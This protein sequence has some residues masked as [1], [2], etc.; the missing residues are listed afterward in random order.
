MDCFYL[1]YIEKIVRKTKRIIF[2]KLDR[3]II[4]QNDLEDRSDLLCMA[5]DYSPRIE[6]KEVLESRTKYVFQN[7]NKKQQLRANKLDS[8]NDKLFTLN[9]K[10][11][12]DF[13]QHIG[14]NNLI[15]VCKCTS[16]IENEPD[17]NQE[18]KQKKKSYSK[19]FEYLSEKNNVNIL[20]IKIHLNLDQDIKNEVITLEGCA[21]L[22]LREI[23]NNL[24]N[25]LKLPCKNTDLYLLID[26]LEESDTL[27][28]QDIET[29]QINLDLQLQFLKHFVFD[30]FI[31]KFSDAP[32][33]KS[34]S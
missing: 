21:N 20:K 16:I 14:E 25:D 18:S 19:K 32:G 17:L 6:N 9:R 2:H 28:V 1:E 8:D 11:S 29:I 24:I 26:H 27:T 3:S 33:S 12:T 23:I 22:T 31:R 34:S 13:T 30:L 7:E 10:S 15:M 4:H 5:L